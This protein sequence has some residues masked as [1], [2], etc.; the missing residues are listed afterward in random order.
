ME[1]QHMGNFVF[2]LVMRFPIPRTAKFFHC[3]TPV[4]PSPEPGQS[5]RGKKQLFQQMVSELET[6]LHA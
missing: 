1:W 2:H 5:A 3:S 4:L 6:N